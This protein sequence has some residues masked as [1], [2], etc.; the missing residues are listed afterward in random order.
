M[1]ALNIII[2]SAQKTVA[3]K[4]APRTVART[5]LRSTAS[6]VARYFACLA[7]IV[8]VAACHGLPE[9]TDE[10][11]TWANNKLYT[12]AQDSLSAGDWSKCAKYFEML[13]GRDPFGHFAQQAQINVAYCNWKDNENAFRDQAMEPFIQLHSKHPDIAAG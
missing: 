7:A 5:T 1:R 8:V 10:T 9:K 11:A 6:R 4:T 12:E 2:E 13:G 3:L